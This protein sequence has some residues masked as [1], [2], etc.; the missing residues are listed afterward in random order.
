M[1]SQLS[2]AAGGRDKNRHPGLT[3]RCAGMA[4]AVTV[5]LLSTG[6][7]Q[8]AVFDPTCDFLPTYAGPKD[9]DLDIISVSAVLSGTNVVLTATVNGTIGTTPGGQYVFGIDRGD[10]QAFFDTGTTP[11][12]AGIVFDAVAF[13]QINPPGSALPTNTFLKSFSVAPI[14]ALPVSVTVSGSTITDV[15]PLADL[16]SDKNLT[17]TAFGF[18]FWTRDS[19]GEIADFAPDHST[20]L[21]SVPEP[22]TWAMLIM[23]FGLVG[24]TARRRKLASLAA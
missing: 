24:F 7:A 2:L 19:I 17:P 10:G 12:G 6:A 23:G 1:E 20:F 14:G 15:V 9:A 8:A 16:P 13:N 4:A 3:A 11:I 21:A 22:A 18:S 5:S